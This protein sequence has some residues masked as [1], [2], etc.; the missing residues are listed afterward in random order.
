MKNGC[1]G[2]PSNFWGCNNKQAAKWTQRLA[3]V[4]NW[5]NINS[6][7]DIIKGCFPKLLIFANVWSNIMQYSSKHVQGRNL[8]ANNACGILL[9]ILILND[10]KWPPPPPPHSYANGCF[11]CW[12]REGRWHRACRT[13]TQQQQTGA[14]TVFGSSRT[15][16]PTVHHVPVI[17]ILM[18]ADRV[19]KGWPPMNRPACFITLWNEGRAR[20]STQTSRFPFAAKC[21]S[22]LRLFCC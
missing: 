3:R 20:P 19:E 15:S 2:S 7:C 8:V 21:T 14:A 12:G 17:W 16:D 4:R 13:W 11:Q 6:S 22:C 1:I 10:V 5:Q 18:L 9:N